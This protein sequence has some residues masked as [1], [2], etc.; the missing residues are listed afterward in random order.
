MYSCIYELCHKAVWTWYNILSGEDRHANYK[1]LDGIIFLSN[2]KIT[3]RNLHKLIQYT[4]QKMWFCLGS[5]INF[6][7]QADKLLHPFAVVKVM[8]SG[9][10]VKC[11]HGL[12]DWQ[13]AVHIYV[14]RQLCFLIGTEMWVAHFEQSFMSRF[15]H[16]VTDNIKKV[17]VTPPPSCKLTKDSHPLSLLFAICILWMVAFK[18]IEIVKWAD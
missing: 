9:V 6:Q 10:F 11:P 15:R 12:P 3:G 7:E 16:K 13:R 1:W 4:Q 14:R 8:G 2:V 18:I 5:T 17:P